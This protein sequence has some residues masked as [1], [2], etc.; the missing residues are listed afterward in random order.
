MAVQAVRR[1]ALGPDTQGHGQW[2]L[3]SCSRCLP[4]MWPVMPMKHTHFILHPWLAVLSGYHKACPPCRVRRLTYGF[5]GEWD[6]RK[7]EIRDIIGGKGEG[8]FFTP[9][10]RRWILGQVG[11]L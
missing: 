10:Q 11:E 7:A 8:A 5:R 4:N 3:Y 2:P 1:L 9:G 6:S